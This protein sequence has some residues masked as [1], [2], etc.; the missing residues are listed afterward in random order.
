MRAECDEGGARR[1]RSAMSAERDEGQARRAPSA[2][3]A[4]RDE[5]GAR[6]GRSATQHAAV[7]VRVTGP[8]RWEPVHAAWV[9]ARP[10][11][12]A[13]C[14]IFRQMWV[15][16]ADSS[17]IAHCRR[18]CHTAVRLCSVTGAAE[19]AHR[20]HVS[21]LRRPPAQGAWGGWGWGVGVVVVGKPGSRFQVPKVRT[22]RGCPRFQVLV[23]VSSG[24][25][26]SRFYYRGPRRPT[27]AGVFLVQRTQF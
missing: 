14:G 12:G 26:G 3:R 9:A 10:G 11:A 24:S 5:G 17:S 21:T 7:V 22:R 1:G 19:C 18:L 4:E 8:G 13:A 2:T 25:A 20:P 15:P 27:P 6:R 23:P 16:V